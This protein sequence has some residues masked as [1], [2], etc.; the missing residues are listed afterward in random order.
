MLSGRRVDGASAL[1]Q[2]FA[3]RADVGIGARPHELDGV[4]YQGFS[5]PQGLRGPAGPQQAKTLGELLRQH[6][7]FADQVAL[8][9]DHSMRRV[10]AVERK[11]RAE[12]RVPGAGE[13][14]MDREIVS[15]AG[16]RFPGPPA[17]EHVRAEG[18][19]H[20]GHYQ[21]GPGTQ[22]APARR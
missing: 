3:E 7:Q 6:V 20:H 12:H 8:P 9:F 22:P 14:I 5:F 2:F 21:L 15:P 13:Q 19:L 4:G 1:C 18:P 10:H 17:P 16:Q 11:D